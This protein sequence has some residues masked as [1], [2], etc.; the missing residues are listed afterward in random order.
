MNNAC[1]EQHLLY[2]VKHGPTVEYD[3]AERLRFRTPDFEVTVEGGAA[4]FTAL[5]RYATPQDARTAAD[6]LVAEWELETLL[7]LGPDIFS[8]EYQSQYTVD[9]SP[10]PGNLTIVAGTG[11]FKFTGHPAILRVSRV[12]YPP[13]PTA[14]LRIDGDIEVMRERYLWCRSDKEPLT[15]TAYFCVTMLEGP[16]RTVSAKPKVRSKTRER[17]AAAYFIDYD[18]ID[19][20]AELSSTKGGNEARKAEGIPSP[21]TVAERNWLDAAIRMMIRRFAEYKADP[22]KTYAQI[23]MADLPKL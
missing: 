15:T 5:A 11:R 17:A 2:R 21:L 8:L 4:D 22:T 16:H 18:V 23:T 6:K 14:A 10:N 12:A 13:P 7:T 19:T 20:A 1:V 3:R 9:R